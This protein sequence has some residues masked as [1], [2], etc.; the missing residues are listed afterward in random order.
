M[1]EDYYEGVR[2]DVLSI[3]PP[4]ARHVL[5]IGCGWGATERELVERGVRVIGIPIDSVIGSCAEQHGIEVVYG[6]FTTARRKLQAERFDCILLTNVLHLIPDPAGVLSSY[7]GLLAPGGSVVI[8]TPNFANLLTQWRRLTG[9]PYYK[10]LGSYQDSG[11]HLTSRR[12]VRRWLQQCGMTATEIRGV[13]SE[14]AQSF[15]RASKGLMGLSF[16]TELLIVG[17]RSGSS[18]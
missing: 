11:V 5:S 17:S 13:F 3:V 2:N 14:R 7:A 9:N 4:N 10:G 12:M 18:R 1:V 8:V 16:A 6:D 15:Q